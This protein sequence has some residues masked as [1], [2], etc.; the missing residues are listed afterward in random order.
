MVQWAIPWLPVSVGDTV[1]LGGGQVVGC[2]LVLFFC[3][4]QT[5]DGEEDGGWQKAGDGLLGGFNV[6]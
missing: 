2:C 4:Q 6:R 3:D 1:G 5:N